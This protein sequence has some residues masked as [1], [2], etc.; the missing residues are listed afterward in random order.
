MTGPLTSLLTFAQTPHVRI[1]MACRNGA[2]YLPEQLASFERQTHRN[3]SLDASD[4]GSTDATREILEAFRQRHPKQV[5]LFD[6]PKAGVAPAFLTLAARAA[7]EAPEAVLALSDQDD[8]WSKVK[9]ARAL[10]WMKRTGDL[11]HDPLVYASRT[12]LTD[13]RLNKLGLSHLHR[14]GPSFRNAL[15]QNIL[16]GNTLMLSPPAA[17]I[18]AQS[19]QAAIAARVSYHDWWIYIML[20]GAGAEIFNDPKPT[21]YYRQHG[22]NQL[23]HHG[24]V[25]GRLKRLGTVAKRHYAEWLDANL[26]ALWANRL[27]LTP[28]NDALLTRFVAARRT[29]GG[30]YARAL[31]ELNI[32]RQTL[33]GDR[34]LQVMARTGRL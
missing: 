17:A 14:R 9:L 24:P 12:I 7:K 30:A 33:Q 25:R 8:V 20:S 18:L 6:G 16:G 34:V 1:I 29:G 28:E 15:V 3:W 13:T 32:H 5:R 2:A 11:G 23:G 22:S 26:A 27:A 10:R 4:D 19:A 21:L 31:R